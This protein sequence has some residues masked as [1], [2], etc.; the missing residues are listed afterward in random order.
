MSGSPTAYSLRSGTTEYVLFR[1]VASFT[2]MYSEYPHQVQF[3]RLEN[4]RVVD[5]GIVGKSEEKKIKQ[6]RPDFVLRDWQGKGP[7]P[8]DGTE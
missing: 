4:G 6:V 7:V 1:L 3:I 2:A 5:R 8:N